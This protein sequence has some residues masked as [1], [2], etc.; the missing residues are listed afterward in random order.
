MF[1]TKIDEDYIARN[2]LNVSERLPEGITASGNTYKQMSLF[3][4][5]EFNRMNSQIITA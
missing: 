1:P 4:Y 3:D 2:L 5:D